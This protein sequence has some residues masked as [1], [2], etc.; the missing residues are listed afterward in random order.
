MKNQFIPKTKEK[1]LYAHLWD[2]E[3]ID[4]IVKGESYLEL[5]PAGGM[6]I[7]VRDA[8][9]VNAMLAHLETDNKYT[10]NGVMKSRSVWTI[11]GRNVVHPQNLERD[12]S[13]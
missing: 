3:K 1:I 11:E 5:K 2:P 12:W 7:G 4:S 9:A 6:A 8:D 13:T 10:R